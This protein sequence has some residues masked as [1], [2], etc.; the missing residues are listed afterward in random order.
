MKQPLI[1]SNCGT[2]GKPIT[3][4]KGSFFIEIILWLCFFIPG[5]IYT[6]WRVTTRENG[7]KACGATAMIPLNTPKGRKLNKDFEK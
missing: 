2:I 7:C 5:I 4:T 6:I 3:I 1:C